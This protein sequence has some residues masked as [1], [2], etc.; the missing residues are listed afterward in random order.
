MIITHRNPLEQVGLCAGLTVSAYNDALSDAE[1]ERDMK[2]RSILLTCA[3]LVAPA[4]LA[5]WGQLPAQFTKLSQDGTPVPDVDKTP[6]PPLP[7]D[8]SCWLASAA[9]LLAGAGYGAGG[10]AQLNAQG[11]YNQLITAFGIAAG[12]APDQAISYWLAWHGKNP[13][14]VDYLPALT[15]TDVTAEYRSLTQSDYTFLK[16]ELQRCQY[17]GVQFENPAHAMTFVGWDDNLGRSIW[18]NSDRTIGVNGNDPYI[19]SFTT[20]WDLVDPGTMTTYMANAN[21]YVTFCP[22]LDKDPDFVVNY[23]VAWAP[24]PAGPAAREAGIKAPAFGPVPGWQGTWY[25]PL[26]PSVGYE[27]FRLNN[28]ADTEM[29]KHVQLLVD[30]YGRDVNYAQEDVRL[31]YFDSHGLEVVV[32]PDVIQLSADN[33][34]VL[35]SW[36][37]DTQPEWEEVLFPSAMNYKILEGTVASWNVATVCV[38]E[39]SVLILLAMGGLAAIHRSRLRAK[40]K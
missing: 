28:E 24:G 32:V 40:R 35:F 26:N 38:P 18:H 31:R 20:T 9:N 5:A 23:D 11:I 33:G 21:G 8:S 39:P 25:D 2:T 4:G 15:Y 13:D 36:A 17:V 14:S 10:T 37:L 19:N 7:G 12:G 29:E 27:P 30:Y 16:G 34:Q 22:G 1:E 3:I 6:L